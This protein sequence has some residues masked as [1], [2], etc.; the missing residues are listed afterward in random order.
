MDRID[1]TLTI[2]LYVLL[3]CI[4]VLAGNVARRIMSLDIA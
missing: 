4:F 1:A 2:V 3:L